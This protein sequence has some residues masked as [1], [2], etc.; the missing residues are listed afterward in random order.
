M[1]IDD[2]HKQREEFKVDVQL[3]W[4]SGFL[5]G[6]SVSTFVL[7]FLNLAFT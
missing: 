4:W 3:L 5:G 1:L 6:V 2:L 7:T